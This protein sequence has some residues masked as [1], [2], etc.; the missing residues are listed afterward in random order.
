MKAEVLELNRNAR[1][2]LN[3]LYGAHVKFAGRMFTESESDPDLIQRFGSAGK[4]GEAIEW[5]VSKDL[6]EHVT[7]DGYRI[8]GYGVDVAEDQELLDA[9]LPAPAQPHERTG[10]AKP[11]KRNSEVHELNGAA[12]RLLDYLHRWH[13]DAG[14]GPF[15][16]GPCN[17]T[18]QACG[19]DAV[20]YRS[21]AGRLVHAGLGAW[22]GTGGVMTITSEGVRAAENSEALDD[23]L[24]IARAAR[25]AEIPRDVAE[26]LADVRQTALDFVSDDDL[27]TI[28]ERD[29]AELEEAVGAGL[30]KSTALL[31][32]SIA[33]ALLLDVLDRRRDIAQSHFGKKKFPADASIEHLVGIA[34]EPDVALLDGLAATLVISIKDYR[35][36]VHPDRERRIRARLDGAT[37]SG[38]LALLRLVVRSLADAQTAGRIDAYVAK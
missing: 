17:E 32:G 9:V 8:T 38:L 33:E 37:T 6:A 34:T 18:F 30:H 20:T 12:R 2:L 35:D 13:L 29:L 11:S 19:L 10:H 22:A 16:I 1:T 36:L 15:R 14:G 5:L 4:Y 25:V 23:A 31:A 3:H 24:P 21:A 28:I 7:Q 27:R 26:S